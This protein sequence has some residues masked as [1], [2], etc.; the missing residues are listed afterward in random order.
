[1]ARLIDWS[2]ER[3]FADRCWTSN[4]MLHCY[5][6]NPAEFE[7]RFVRGGKGPSLGRPAVMGSALHAWWLEGKTPAGRAMDPTCPEDLRGAKTW[8]KDHDPAAVVLNGK[9]SETVAG[10]YDALNGSSFA[11]QLLTSS[12]WTERVVLFELGGV[13]CKSKIDLYGTAG[14]VDLKTS[15][16]STPGAFEKSLYE[17]GYLYQAAFYREAIRQLTGEKLPFCFIVACNK[18]PYPV[19]PYDPDPDAMD[20]AAD[21]NNGHLELLADSYWNNHWPERA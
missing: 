20:L 17:Y 3:Y 1:M 15:R 5:R 16:H 4:S 14:I 19:F 12:E 21:D 18:P 8:A 11:W 10:M 7:R 2:D 9:E 6:Q 13:N